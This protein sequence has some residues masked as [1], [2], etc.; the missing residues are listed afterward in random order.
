[1]DR[2]PYIIPSFKKDHNYFTK[3]S[4]HKGGP[5][6]V[7]VSSELYTARPLIADYQEHTIAAILIEGIMHISKKPSR[8]LLIGDT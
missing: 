7:V 8:P 3:D 4:H 2:V 6:V 1:M 5:V